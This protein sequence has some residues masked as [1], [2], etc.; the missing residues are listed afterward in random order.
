VTHFE[1]H[2]N[3][4]LKLKCMIS[5]AS[6]KGWRFH[7]PPNAAWQWNPQN[8]KLPSDHDHSIDRNMWEFKLLQIG[9]PCCDAHIMVLKDVLSQGNESKWQSMLKNAPMLQPPCWW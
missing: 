5:A 4:C 2:N 8:F 7:Q 3:V 9:Q 1:M 6:A